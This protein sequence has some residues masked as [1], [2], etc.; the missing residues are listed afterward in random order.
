MKVQ[1][2]YYGMEI[3][4]DEVNDVIE[5]VTAAIQTNFG[6]KIIV[7]EICAVSCEDARDEAEEIIN[8]LIA[9]YMKVKMTQEI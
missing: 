3:M 7:S 9:H 1:D 5:K 2:I 6:T 4:V 8:D